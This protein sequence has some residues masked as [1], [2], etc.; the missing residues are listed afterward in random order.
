VVEQKVFSI[1]AAT[2][3]G[4]RGAEAMLETVIGRLSDAAPGVRFH[5]FSY[6][7]ASDRRL[8]ADPRVRLHSSTPFA[9]VA[10]ILPWSLLFGLLRRI[11]G[12]GVFRFAPG[13][14]QALARSTAL[15]DLA[16]VAFIDGRGKFLPFNVLTLL[17]AMLLGTPVVKMPQALGPFHG[18]ANRLAAGFLLPRCAM[19][20]ARGARTAEF[21]AA[22]GF[23]GLRHA[24]ADDIAF[25]F[26]ARW[27]LTREGAAEL[28]QRLE[29]IQALRA[30]P[31]I[32]GIA[33]ICP[34]AVLA[35]Q[36]R[37]RGG[38]YE[39]ALARLVL[40]LTA[41]GFGVVLFP[42]A[43]R[44][45]AGEAER[46][47]DLPLM[48]RLH[49]AAIASGISRPPLLVDFDI[50][51][52]GIK[53]VIASADVLMVSRFHAMVGAL[54][55]GVPTAVLGWS[56]KYAEVMARFGLERE[57]MDYKSLAADALV[58]SVERLFGERER[59][60]AAILERLPQVQASAERP[61]L[62]LL[63]PTLGA[64]LA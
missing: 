61:V 57:V 47:N 22:S 20:W 16:G 25:N 55:L 40:G 34:S 59:V 24:Q 14:V 50:N 2:L 32:R 53:R 62:A 28:E 11:L 54:S 43:T 6:Y 4:N 8:L 39:A 58:E 13:A 37:K 31:G 49:A 1:I 36:S 5:V 29:A 41:A 26:D 52:A 30:A 60:R 17:P 35:V 10:W 3:H 48:R 7:P 38:G 33:G 21:L 56:H 9:L 12:S 51:A 15:V 45:A 46:N 63:R 44:A 64:D 18:A 19:I 27:S 23:R 42:N